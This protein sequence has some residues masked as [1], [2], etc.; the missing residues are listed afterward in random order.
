[1]YIPMVKVSF[2]WP[3]FALPLDGSMDSFF[4][5]H[6]H[7]ASMR[8]EPGA[9]AVDTARL[10]RRHTVATDATLEDAINTPRRKGMLVNAI[11]S[12]SAMLTLRETETM[13][14]TVAA[15]RAAQPVRTSLR[16]HVT[17]RMPRA[18]SMWTWRYACRC[19]PPYAWPHTH[20]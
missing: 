3:G 4:M 6:Q 19:T 14:A 11:G 16:D 1:M 12:P 20:A 15:A 7:G 13:A 8:R 10:T 17:C 2:M 18:A 5:A 9:A